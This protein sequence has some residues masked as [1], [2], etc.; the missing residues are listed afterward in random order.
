MA[1][2]IYSSFTAPITTLSF[3]LDDTLYQN[4]EV[5]QLAEQAQFDAVCERVP[6]AKELGKEIWI[7]LKWQVLKQFPELCHDVTEWRRKVIADGLTELKVSGTDVIKFTDEIYDIFYQARSNFVVPES[8]FDVLQQL[9]QKFTLIAVTNGN[10]DFE[11]I[12]LAPY[13]DGYYRAGER[14]T[15]MKPYSDTLDLAC[16]DLNIEPESILHIGDNVSTDVQAAHNAKC[17]SLWFN[18]ENNQYP[19]GFSLPNGEYSHLDD[20]LQLL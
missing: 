20:L 12:G 2:R 1:L 6:H 18:P 8:S 3:D 9:K 14:G 4:E 7:E 13:F 15:R 17:A 5:I 11:R 16:Q 19:R 10:A